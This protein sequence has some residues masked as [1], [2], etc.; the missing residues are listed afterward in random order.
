MTVE[1]LIAAQ[2]PEDPLYSSCFIEQG[3]FGEGLGGFLKHWKACYKQGHGVPRGG[4]FI[5]L[6]PRTE[7]QISSLRKQGDLA[8][9]SR[10][11]LA[12]S[13]EVHDCQM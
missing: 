7:V 13:A 9:V 8:V 3:V 2:C 5:V 11:L 6:Q 12:D 10:A 4:E 1:C